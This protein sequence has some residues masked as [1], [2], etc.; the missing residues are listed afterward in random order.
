M[1]FLCSVCESHGVRKTSI[2]ERQVIRALVEQYNGWKRSDNP[3]DE[4]DFGVVY[5]LDSGAWTNAHPGDTSWLR[6]IFWKFEY[7]DRSTLGPSHAPWDG[8]QTLRVLNFMLPSEYGIYDQLQGQ[9][10]FHNG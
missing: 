5:Q 8:E 10:E 2:H 1:G 3:Y 7:R 9:K 4:H 6:A